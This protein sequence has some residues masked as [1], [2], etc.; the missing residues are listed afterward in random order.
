MRYVNEYTCLSYGD[1]DEEVARRL[2]I[3]SIHADFLCILFHCGKSTAEVGASD[4]IVDLV[5]SFWLHPY[6]S[7]DEQEFASHALSI[8]LAV[9]DKTASHDMHWKTIMDSSKRCDREPIIFPIAK[10]ANGA[11]SVRAA[12]LAILMQNT[13]T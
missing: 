6:A 1:S 10:L 5:L 8:L 7:L 11:A 3:M 9:L 13:G 4:M 2:A 12:Q